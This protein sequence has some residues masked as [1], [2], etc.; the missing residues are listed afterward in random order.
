MNGLQDLGGRGDGV[1]AIRVPPQAMLE[2]DENEIDQIQLLAQLLCPLP[3]QIIQDPRQL[4]NQR[5][6]WVT[7]VT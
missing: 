3:F 5:L 4:G 2:A 7:A 6:C 1:N